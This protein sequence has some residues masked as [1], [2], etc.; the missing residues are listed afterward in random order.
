MNW[1]KPFLKTS[2]HKKNR[3]VKMPH[4]DKNYEREMAIWLKF[5]EIRLKKSKKNGKNQREIAACEHNP[6]SEKAYYSSNTVFSFY[7]KIRAK[8]IHAA[9]LLA[10][11]LYFLFRSDQNHYSTL[12]SMIM[13]MC[14]QILKNMDGRNPETT[15][16]ANPLKCHPTTH[17][18]KCASNNLGL[19]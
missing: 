13:K 12:T 10:F 11:S 15:R 7:F 17:H 14:E 18:T 19:S 1:E 5:R 9:K 8:K 6:S 4:V 16:S 2:D 3:N